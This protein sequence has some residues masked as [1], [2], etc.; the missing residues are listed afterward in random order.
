MRRSRRRGWKIR[1]R[2]R[3][4]GIQTDTCRDHR[5]SSHHCYGV[6]H[7]IQGPRTER[8]QKRPPSYH[9]PSP[10][11]HSPTPGV[12][13]TDPVLLHMVQVTNALGLAGGRGRG[14]ELGPH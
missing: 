6:S 10:F 13:H 4:P 9:P 11:S 8:Q 3:V 1:G 2:R 14:G 12:Q 7:S 5:F